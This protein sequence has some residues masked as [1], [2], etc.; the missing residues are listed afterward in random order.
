MKPEIIK[1]KDIEIVV[2]RKKIKHLHLTIIASE[3]KVRMSIPLNTSIEVAKAFAIKKYLWI[4]RH[5]GSG[6]KYKRARKKEFVNGEEHY[7]KGSRFIMQIV[8]AKRPRIEIKDKKYIYFYIPRRYTL[9][10]KQK[11]YE[12]WQREELKKELEALVPKWEKIMGL[13][14][15]EVRIKKMKT[16]W[17][18]CNIGAK[19]I[20]INLE[21][22]TR[23]RR[24]LEYI[25]VHELA[26]FRER[27]HND[28][29][30]AILDKYMP[31]WKVYKR[32]LQEFIP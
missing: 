23:P 1:I 29:F 5:I 9:K 22:I 18:T 32:E 8:S 6:E 26:H 11:Y 13:K 15:K 19:R 28:R 27:Y 17:G 16:R 14:A 2:L 21:L 10:Q 31:N 4:K 30:K 20:W 3:G 25:I 24:L 7:F 12:K